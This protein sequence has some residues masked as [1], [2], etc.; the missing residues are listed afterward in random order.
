MGLWMEGKEREGVY[1]GQIEDYKNRIDSL[2]Y[3]VDKLKEI[4]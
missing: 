4:L 2:E 3:Q 1:K